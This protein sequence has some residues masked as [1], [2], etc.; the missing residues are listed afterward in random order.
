MAWFRR[1]KSE[2][3]DVQYLLAQ[4]HEATPLEPTPNAVTA[5]EHTASVPSVTFGFS[6]T[7]ED[8]F[9]IA[10][11]GTVVTGRIASGTVS[12]GQTVRLTRRDASVRAIEI[13]GVEMFGKKVDV[14]SAGDNVGLLLCGA[15][16]ADVGQG[17]VVTA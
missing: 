3:M 5:L 10:G 1:N 7:V 2:S 16:K 6:M 15:S 14:A 11:R 4:G 8:V 9:T 13:I 12:N 17:D